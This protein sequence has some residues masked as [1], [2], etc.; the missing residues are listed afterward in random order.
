M[1]RGG[2][3]VRC[4]SQLYTDCN[5]QAD[6]I[7]VMAQPSSVDATNLHRVMWILW[8]MFLLTFVVLGFVAYLNA[9]N[10]TFTLTTSGERSELFVPLLT[11]SLLAILMIFPA[12]HFLLFKPRADK[13]FSNE[14]AFMSRYFITHIIS[15]ALCEF[16]V[17]CG[18]LLTLHSGDFS[19]FLQFALVG[20]LVLLTLVPGT[21]KWNE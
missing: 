8:Q 20:V 9:E 13:A 5:A 16:V 15:L 18:L 3:K 12:R 6:R 19:Y 17:I 11:A 1:H 2:A 14:D 10:P 7:Y 21:P 4:F